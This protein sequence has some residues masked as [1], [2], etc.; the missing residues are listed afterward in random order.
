MVAQQ[1]NHAV[2]TTPA[3]A[4]IYP[5]VRELT[6]SMAKGQRLLGLDIGDKNRRRGDL[7]PVVHARQ[8]IENRA[9][10]K[11][12]R[13]RDRRDRT[14]GRKRGYRRPAC[15]PARQH[16]R[17]RGAPAPRRPGT[18]PWKSPPRL[19]LPAAFWDERLSTAAIERFLV[20]EADM[21]RKR[22]KDV[23]DKMAAAYILQGA[24]DSL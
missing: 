5:N 22:R 11:K 19:G 7:R 23:V 17:H 3:R 8:P 20:T 16:G 10:R 21:T 15:R 14:T 13:S 6:A 18:S 24:L 4:Q 9:A 1:G 12:T 2:M